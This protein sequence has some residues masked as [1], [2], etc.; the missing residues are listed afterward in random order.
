[1]SFVLLQDIF[2]EFEDGVTKIVAYQNEEQQQTRKLTGGI[3]ISYRLKK[4]LLSPWKPVTRLSL[5]V[6]GGSGIHSMVT[7]SM[8]LIKG[9]RAALG[10][11]IRL[12]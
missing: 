3:E 2:W 11:R 9:L 8:Y 7:P 4:E 10:S 5:S 12:M 1:M 6:L